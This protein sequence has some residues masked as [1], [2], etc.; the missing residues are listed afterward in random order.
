MI[1][2]RIYRFLLHA[3]PPEFRAKYGREM[4]L[5][6]RDQCRDGDVRAPGFWVR[7]FWDVVRSAP[8]LRAHATQTVEVFMKIAAV[9]TV[10]LGAFGILGSVREWIAGSR[11][12]M[13]T[14][15]VLAVVLGV[16]A[17]VVLVGAG[18]A[19]LRQ[20]R[21]GARLALV[22]SLVLAIAA[23]LLFPWMGILAQLAGIALPVG[24]LIALYWPSKSSTLGTA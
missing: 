7:V 16:F 12:P 24:L 21:H 8:A 2:E 1:A 22:V 10:L 6:F 13:S 17:F 15:Y 14:T 20:R 23:R 3:Y 19:I 9:V 5:V 4:V 18:V 11:Q